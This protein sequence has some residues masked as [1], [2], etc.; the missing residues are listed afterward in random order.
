LPLRHEQQDL[1][2]VFPHT[3]AEAS[4]ALAELIHP[5]PLPAAACA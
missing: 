1:A 4:L 5:V 3:D 2:F